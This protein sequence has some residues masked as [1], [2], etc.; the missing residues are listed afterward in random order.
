MVL[1]KNNRTRRGVRV[2][3]ASTQDGFEYKK[4]IELL[5]LFYSLK[6]NKDVTIIDENLTCSINR[7]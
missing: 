4:N 2:C 5:L 1:Y 6:S 7:T 3:T